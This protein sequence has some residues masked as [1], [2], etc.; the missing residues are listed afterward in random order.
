MLLT[1]VMLL[2]NERAPLVFVILWIAGV[3]P[4]SDWWCKFLSL[5]FNEELCFADLVIAS[6]Y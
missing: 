6:H 2:E 5:L 1:A 4:Q 3:H